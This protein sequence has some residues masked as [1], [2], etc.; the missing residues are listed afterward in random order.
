MKKRKKTM[1]KNQK[2]HS[3]ATNSS[4]NSTNVNGASIRGALNYGN[5]FKA[6]CSG[7]LLGTAPSVCQLCSTC[8][9][10]MGCIDNNYC[11]STTSSTTSSS[12]YSGSSTNAYVAS[13]YSTGTQR[14]NVS[15]LSF[16]FT[17]LL[18]VGVLSSVSLVYYK[19]SQDEMRNHVRDV[20]AEYMP[21]QDDSNPHQP[22]QQTS[23][24][25]F[26]QNQH[27]IIRNMVG[28]TSTNGYKGP[29]NNA[30]HNTTQY[31]MDGPNGP[32]QYH[33]QQYQQPQQQHQFQVQH[34]QQQQ[35]TPM[36][37]DTMTTSLVSSS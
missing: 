37:A 28:T 29:T 16:V 31:N 22:P 2:Q 9:D 33:H 5:V 1:S 26:F 8:L 15:Y 30:F 24:S 3:I 34:Q 18:L 35:Q 19:R 12:S 27:N 10:I 11:G 20:L 36:N 7:F 13:S 6:I 23:L 32:Q 17:M 21:L 4:S 25:S 14:G